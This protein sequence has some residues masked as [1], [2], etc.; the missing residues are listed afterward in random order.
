[1]TES[2][3]QNW[4]NWAII[5]LG[6]FTLFLWLWNR[7]NAKP[8]LPSVDVTDDTLSTEIKIDT[9][10][11]LGPLE[12]SEKENPT[13]EELNKYDFFKAH[14][15]EE[16]ESEATLQAFHQLEKSLRS[17]NLI[18]KNHLNAALFETEPAFNFDHLFKK[19][20]RA[21]IY[22]ACEIK[23]NQEREVGL[24]SG[25]ADVY[26]I[27]LNHQ[28]VT[29]VS[30]RRWIEKYTDISHIKLKKGTNLLLIKVSRQTGWG[31]S[32]SLTNLQNAKQMEEDNSNVRLL[33]SWLLPLNGN[34]KKRKGATSLD[35]AKKIKLLNAK[36]ESFPW[37]GFSGDTAA[38]QG[39]PEG[40]YT[41]DARFADKTHREDFYIGDI[42][43]FCQEIRRE[44]ASTLQNTKDQDAINLEAPIRRLEY[45]ANPSDPHRE[46]ILGEIETVEWIRELHNLTSYLKANDSSY[47][48][49]PGKHLR[50]SVSSMDNTLQHY[51]VFAPYTE[52]PPKEGFPLV[53]I[54]PATVDS[55]PH[56]LESLHLEFKD[57][58]ETYTRES[59]KH[60][61]V[62]LW[63]FA[64]NEQRSLR[65]N[66][67]VFESIQA[68]QKDYF[69]N[70]NKIYLTGGC[71]GGRDALMMAARNPS[72]FAAIGAH[73]PGSSADPSPEGASLKARKEEFKYSSPL[74]W[75]KNLHNIPLYLIHGDLDN[76][77]PLA[78]STH[79]AEKAKE[80]LI[81]V[82]LDIIEGGTESYFPERDNQQIVEILNFFKG[83]ER[84]KRPR[85][86]VLQ[87]NNTSALSS[88]WLS[89][90][91]TYQ[92]REFSLCTAEFTSPNELSITTEGLA[93]LGID[94]ENTPWP[95]SEGLKVTIDGEI[96]FNEIPQET[97]LTF[98][99]KTPPR[100]E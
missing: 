80:A 36:G 44:F 64:R 21:S 48:S 24:V 46:P 61:F 49:V 41:I 100:F 13:K 16:R 38:L 84:K 52:N 85:K 4:L 65:G 70:S 50:G 51:Q 15:I 31:L 83:K 7:E 17:K 93:S 10:W 6:L 8:Q 68:V 35:E 40:L 94:L 76:H 87:V 3:T 56:F 18:A 12:L 9:F 71:A 54:Y 77:I 98:Q 53:V 43:K 59:Q 14:Q 22:M 58:I 73:T 92:T 25:G 69:I 74:A 89:V 20:K 27:W 19:T 60:G 42:S 23:S 88:D 91:P 32:L 82:R 97:V 2:K 28:L 55:R 37:N 57:T 96:Y 67:D 79:Y 34:L 66:A 26:R 99:L 78:Y 30:S 47:R 72:Y 33:S 81:D 95:S 62:V 11:V 39:L 90:Q 1:V 5:I 45:L 29:E 86:V 75:L 63:A